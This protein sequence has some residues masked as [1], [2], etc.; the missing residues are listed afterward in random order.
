[1]RLFD[2]HVLTHKTFCGCRYGAFKK[3]QAFLVRSLSKGI[4]AFFQPGSEEFCFKLLFKEEDNELSL[5]FE[6]RE[7]GITETHIAAALQARRKV[8]VDNRLF[9]IRICHGDLKALDLQI[10]QDGKGDTGHKVIDQAH[11]HIPITDPE[12][13]K[14]LFDR[15]AKGVLDGEDRIRQMPKRAIEHMLWWFVTRQTDSLDEKTRKYCSKHGKIPS[16]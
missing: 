15:I 2:R 9:L 5:F 6:N 1:M 13:K 7:M 3:G 4:D 14:R 11:A 12:S 10:V 16:N 8:N